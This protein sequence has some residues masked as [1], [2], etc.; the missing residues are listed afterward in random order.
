MQAYLYKYTIIS[1]IF[2]FVKTLRGEFAK[3]FRFHPL[4]RYAGAPPEGEPDVRQNLS[5]KASP[6]G[7]AYFEIRT[8]L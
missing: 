6:K 7:E 4:T 3:I 2:A 8:R 1:Q 5:I